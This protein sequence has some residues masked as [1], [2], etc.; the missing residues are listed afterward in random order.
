MQDCASEA[1]AAATLHQLQ[2]LNEKLL[3][4]EVCAGC[5]LDTSRALHLGLPLRSRPHAVQATASAC[6]SAA[7][8]VYEPLQGEAHHARSTIAAAKEAVERLAGQAQKLSQVHSGTQQLLAELAPQL[9][10]TAPARQAGRG[11]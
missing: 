11:A 1:I 8:P 3:Q 2:V 9:K 4:L 10:S 5:N 6:F 7:C